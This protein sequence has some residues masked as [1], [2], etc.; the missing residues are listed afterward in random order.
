[1]TK[2]AGSAEPMSTST[3]D[4]QDAIEQQRVSIAGEIHDTLLPYLFATRMRLE[5][6][7]HRLQSGEAILDSS[8]VTTPV[9]CEEITKAIETLCQAMTIGRQ[10]IGELHSAEVAEITWSNQLAETSQRFGSQ[11]GTGVTVEGDFDRLVND[12]RRRL[13]ARRVAQESIRNA[14]RH[15]RASIV[16]VK[17]EE[18]GDQQVALT[19][20]DNGRGFEPTELIHGHGLQIMEARAKSIGGS[21][22][23]QSQPGGPTRVSL[24]CDRYDAA[25]AD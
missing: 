22:T 7:V 25:A 3:N 24:I 18:Q 9:V 8:S 17:V 16:L 5:T 11:S 23:I 15:G 2:R 20:T 1:L 12:A 4:I 13:A 6:L 10:M 19:I 21:L 14:I